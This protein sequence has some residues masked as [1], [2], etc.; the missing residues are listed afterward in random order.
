MESVQ[1]EWDSDILTP[2]AHQVLAR[3]YRTIEDN[4]DYLVYIEGHASSEGAYEY[5][6]DLSE[7]R[8]RVVFEYLANHGIP[9]A[10]LWAKGFSSSVPLQS[11][12]TLDGRVANRRVIFRL[13]AMTAE[14]GAK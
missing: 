14:G 5:N 8:A 2:A 12:G 4:K 1:F 13:E 10:R 9:R 6:Q 11:N 3:A 7:R